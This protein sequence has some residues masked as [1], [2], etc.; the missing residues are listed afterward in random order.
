MTDELY[1]ALI[2]F[3]LFLIKHTLADYF[4]QTRRM[5]TNRS[6]YA[7]FGRLQHAVIHGALSFVT[8]L[9]VGLPSWV[10]VVLFAIDTTAHFH[11]DWIKGM[12]SDRTGDGPEKAA[13]WRAFGTDQLAHQLTY[14]GMVWFWVAVLMP[15]PV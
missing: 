15:V 7:H 4:L 11:I 3:A 1:V 6:V 10:A 8:V 12:Y 5:L 9:V 2:L 13:Y 14:V